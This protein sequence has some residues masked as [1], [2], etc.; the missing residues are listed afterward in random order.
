MGV[1]CGRAAAGSYARRLDSMC[2][3]MLCCAVHSGGAAIFSLHYMYTTE[4]CTLVQCSAAASRLECCLLCLCLWL[5][6]INLFAEESGATESL[7]SD[8]VTQPL[9]SS[10]HVAS[11]SRRGLYLSLSNSATPLSS[12]L[13]SPPTA[14]LLGA[15]AA[16]NTTILLSQRVRRLSEE[17][18]VRLC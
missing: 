12:P 3:V 5:T 6:P 14:T 11:P 17:A 1:Q 15:A 2:C 16:T 10:L 9:P 4:Y 18:A 13:I 8:E 7:C